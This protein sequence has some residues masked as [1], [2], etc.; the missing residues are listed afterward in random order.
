MGQSSWVRCG[1]V[2]HRAPQAAEL[3]SIYRHGHDRKGLQTLT[4]CAMTEAEETAFGWSGSKPKRATASPD[5]GFRSRRFLWFLPL[6][7]RARGAARPA[8]RLSS[9]VFL[10]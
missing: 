8:A 10:P 7:L 9:A 6:E 5:V 4:C 1:L 3:A 2:A